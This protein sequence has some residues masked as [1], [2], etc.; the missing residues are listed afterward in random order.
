MFITLTSQLSFIAAYT[1]SEL[2][3]PVEILLQFTICMSNLNAFLGSVVNSISHLDIGL[4]TQTDTCID[5]SFYLLQ[6]SVMTN[7]D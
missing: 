1:A 3:L 4:K 2:A 7:L 5:Y 6:M